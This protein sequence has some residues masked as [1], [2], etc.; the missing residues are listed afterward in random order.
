MD[1]RKIGSFHDR[2]KFLTPLQDGTLLFYGELEGAISGHNQLALF[3]SDKNLNPVWKKVISHHN[4]SDDKSGMEVYAREL[5]EMNDGSLIYLASYTAFNNAQNDRSIRLLKL[6]SDGTVNWVKGFSN[7]RADNPQAISTDF[8][9]GFIICGSSNGYSPGGTTDVQIVKV[10]SEG[11]VE[12]AKVMGGDHEDVAYK[13]VKTPDNGYL[14]G[15]ITNSFGKGQNDVLLLKLNQQ[16]VLQWAKTFGGMGEEAITNLFTLD[17]RVVLSGYSNSFNKQTYQTFLYE[18]SDFNQLDAS[19]FEDITS[20]LRVENIQLNTFN[21]MYSSTSF[22]APSPVDLAADAPS[23]SSEEKCLSCL[24]DEAYYFEICPETG[25]TLT[26]DASSPD[27]TAYVWENGSGNATLTVNAPGVYKVVVHYAFC[28]LTKI[29][30]VGVTGSGEVNLGTDISS[31]EEKSVTLHAPENLEDGSFTWS[32]GSTSRNLH[33]TSGG[34]YWLTHQSSCGPITDTVNI[35]IGSLPSIDL[36]E[37]LIFCR[38]EGLQLTA[39]ASTGTILWQDSIESSAIE[40]LS[41]G[42]YWASVENE[43]GLASDTVEVQFSTIE[44]PFIPNV[45]TPNKDSF[46]EVFVIDEQL[47][48]ATLSIYNRWGKLVYHSPAYD[49]SWTGEMLSKGAYFVKIYDPC[50]GKSFKQA[51]TILD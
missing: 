1:S 11:N 40:I 5:L 42:K 35:H 48:G 30:N 47:I 28:Q 7:I 25:E 38:D 39:K 17:S 45:I 14:L 36:G 13:I 19:C 4:S 37:D 18:I 44:T 16:G 43:C 27:A 46:N 31:C 9:N 49:N 23:L 26:L 10:D 41:P 22:S 50:S 32:T 3:K 8:A 51:L 6:A 21:T 12:W 24:E 2:I 29:F 33:V 15:G 34:T 20:R